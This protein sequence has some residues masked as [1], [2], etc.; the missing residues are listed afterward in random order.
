MRFKDENGAVI[1]EFALVL[2]LLAFL[3]FGMI[4]FGLVLFN[5]QVITNASREAA[6]A[7]IVVDL[8]TG[9]SDYDTYLIDIAKDYC[10][11]YLIDLGGSAVPQVQPTYTATGFGNNLQVEVTYDYHFLVF[12]GLAEM[13]GASDWSTV[14]LYARSVMRFE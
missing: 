2:P 12:G 14:N 8:D 6:R 5:K 13:F 1:A 7:G 10:S 9:E 3:L 4:E 11:N